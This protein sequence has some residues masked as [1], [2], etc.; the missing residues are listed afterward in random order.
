MLHSVV[1]YISVNVSAE[2]YASIFWRWKI[3]TEGS[4]VTLLYHI[5]HPE[6]LTPRVVQLYYIYLRYLSLSYSYKI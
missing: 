6:K 5:H 2:S 1:W 3:E 4:S